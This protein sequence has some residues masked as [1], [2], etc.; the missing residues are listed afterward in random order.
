MSIIINLCDAKNSIIL[1]M[2]SHRKELTEIP[3]NCYD[4]EIINA[5]KEAEA[6]KSITLFDFR[7][8]VIQYLLNG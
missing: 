4:E 6:S 2:G 3:T 7:I 8:Q 1:I 5:N